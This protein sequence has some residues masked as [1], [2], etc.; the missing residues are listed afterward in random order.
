MNSNV[1]QLNAIRRV[2][3][4]EADAE[5][6]AKVNELRAEHAAEKAEKAQELALLKQANASLS[7]LLSDE[8]AERAR[9]KVEAAELRRL[10]DVM[11]AKILA[12]LPA[13]NE[14]Q[15]M[16][17][18]SKAIDAVGN[19]VIAAFQTM[20]RAEPQPPEYVLEVMSKFQDGRIK[21]IS[22]KPKGK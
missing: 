20:E 16:I 17:D 6:Q 12:A 19:R 7:K 21:S 2:I 15:E 1:H 4:G 11:T 18:Y 8:K 5:A 14:K 10:F 9:E 22:A 3:Q 13:E